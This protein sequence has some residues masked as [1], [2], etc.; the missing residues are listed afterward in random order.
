MLFSF[1]GFAQAQSQPQSQPNAGDAFCQVPNKKNPNGTFVNNQPYLNEGKIYKPGEIGECKCTKGKCVL[2]PKKVTPTGVDGKPIDNV[3]PPDN[4]TPGTAGC[5][6]LS[7][8]PTKPDPLIDDTGGFGQPAT[9]D[10]TKA[11]TQQPGGT[12]P[13]DSEPTDSGKKESTLERVWDWLTASPEPVGAPIDD[14]SGFGIPEGPGSALQPT[15]RDYSQFPL[16]DQEVELRQLQSTFGFVDESGMIAGTEEPGLWQRAWDATKSFATDLGKAMVDGLGSIGDFTTNDEAFPLTDSGE[17]LKEPPTPSV[18]KSDPYLSALSNLKEYP[19][20]SNKE[21]YL[22]Q[23][24]DGTLK[25]YVKDT[26]TGD[27]YRSDIARTYEAAERAALANEQN[28]IA[29]REMLQNGMLSPE[30]VDAPAAAEARAAKIREGMALLRA[31]DPAAISAALKSQERFDTLGRTTDSALAYR[32]RQ[33]SDSVS[34]GVL[35]DLF[36]DRKYF[37][38]V[39]STAWALTGR[40]A[41]D[42]LGATVGSALDMFG[43]THPLLEIEYA[44]DPDAR[45]Q[46]VLRG[47]AETGLNVTAFGAVRGIRPSLS[48][49]LTTVLRAADGGIGF[50]P[51]FVEG[52]SG[53]EARVAAP[54]VSD[55]ATS[56]KGE[57]NPFAAEAR[58]YQNLYGNLA[59]TDFVTTGQGDGMMSALRA[60]MQARGISIPGAADNLATAPEGFAAQASR[61]TSPVSEAPT[62]TSPSTVAPAQSIITPRAASLAESQAIRAFEAAGNEASVVARLQENGLNTNANR[63]IVR[64][65]TGEL[66]SVRDTRGAYVDANTPQGQAILA[67]RLRPLEPAP[68]NGLANSGANTGGQVTTGF[69][70]PQTIPNI[71]NAVLGGFWNSFTG[72]PS[73]VAQSFVGSVIPRFGY[74]G[75]ANSGAIVRMTVPDVA[76]T[77]RPPVSFFSGSPASIS[78]VTRFDNASGLGPASAESAVGV[79]SPSAAAVRL[80][81]ISQQAV[82]AARNNGWTIAEKSTTFTNFLNDRFGTPKPLFYY[83]KAGKEIAPVENAALVP[84]G[85]ISVRQSF[86]T[87]NI[88]KVIAVI[89]ELSAIGQADGL[90]TALFG[91]GLGAQG[92]QLVSD[93][94]Q[95]PLLGRTTPFLTVEGSTVVLNVP[96]RT[97]SPFS[98]TFDRVLDAGAIATPARLTPPVTE[99]SPGRVVTANPIENVT[100]LTDGAPVTTARPGVQPFIENGIPNPSIVETPA[101]SPTQISPSRAP[102]GFQVPQAVKN[103]ASGVWE[104]VKS[105]LSAINPIQPARGQPTQVAAAPPSAEA[106]ASVSGPMIS[107]PPTGPTVR[108]LTTFYA[109]GAGGRVEG[110]WATSRPN[111]EGLKNT[112]GD[113]I[114][115]TLDDVRLGRSTYVTLASDPSRYGQFFNLGDVTYRSPLDGKTYTIKNVIGYVHDTGSAFRGRP[116]KFDVAVGDFRG[117]SASRGQAF[118]NSQPYGANRYHAWQQ[119]NPERARTYLASGRGASPQVVAAG[120]TLPQKIVTQPPSLPSVAASEIA[121]ELAA[122]AREAAKAKAGEVAATIKNRSIFASAKD[123][124]AKPLVVSKDRIVPSANE[125]RVIARNV[126]QAMGGPEA[127]RRIYTYDA[128]GTLRDLESGKIIQGFVMKPV[129]SALEKSRLSAGYNKVSGQLVAINEVTR[130]VL[131]QEALPFN[132]GARPT[133]IGSNRHHSFVP[134]PDGKRILISYAVDY[135]G[136]NSIIKAA[137]T[138]AAN[139]AQW[140]LNTELAAAGSQTS[141]PLSAGAR[142]PKARSIVHIDVFPQKIARTWGSAPI[143]KFLGSV[144][145]IFAGP[146]RVTPTYITQAQFEQALKRAHMGVLPESGASR[147]AEMPGRTT[148]D[149]DRTALNIFKARDGDTKRALFN[150]ALKMADQKFDDTILYKTLVEIVGKTEPAM[151]IPLTAAEITQLNRVLPPELALAT[152]PPASTVVAEVKSPTVESQKE[153]SPRT[154]AETKPPSEAKSDEALKPIRASSAEAPKASQEPSLLQQID[155][156]VTGWFGYSSLAWRNLMSKMSQQTQTPQATVNTVPL[157]PEIEPSPPQARGPITTPGDLPLTDENSIGTLRGINPTPPHAPSPAA[158]PEAASEPTFAKRMLGLLK[159]EA[160]LTDFERYAAAL[161]RALKPLAPPDFPSAAPSAA[162]SAVPDAETSR[163]ISAITP[164]QPPKTPLERHEEVAM[165][166]FAAAQRMQSAGLGMSSAAQRWDW[167]AMARANNARAAAT[168]DFSTAV[169]AYKNSALTTTSDKNKITGMLTIVQT[170]NQ[171][172]LNNQPSGV[173]DALGKQAQLTS[174]AAA[175]RNA[176][177]AIVNTTDRSLM[178]AIRNAMKNQTITLNEAADPLTRVSA[179]L[180]ALQE[181]GYV[182]QAS[183]HLQN[184]A[185]IRLAADHASKL[186]QANLNDTTNAIASTP[187]LPPERQAAIRQALDLVIVSSK[188]VDSILEEYSRLTPQKKLAGKSDLATALNEEGGRLAKGL[189]TLATT[190]AAAQPSSAPRRVAGPDVLEHLRAIPLSRVS[191]PARSTLS[192]VIE[193]TSA[194]LEAR[195]GFIDASRHPNLETRAANVQ[196]ANT[197]LQAALRDYVASSK[198][199]IAETATD[200]QRQRLL[201]GVALVERNA[202]DVSGELTRFFTRAQA[203]QLF[204][205]NALIGRLAELDAPMSA[206]VAEINRGVANAIRAKNN[207]GGI[208]GGELRY[209]GEIKTPESARA[210]EDGE[211]D[212]TIAGG[213]LG[214]AVIAKY[215]AQYGN[216]AIAFVVKASKAAL[217]GLRSGAVNMWEAARASFARNVHPTT[218]VPTTPSQPILRMTPQGPQFVPG[219]QG[220]PTQGTTPQPAPAKPAAPPAQSTPSAGAPAPAPAPAPTAPR[221]AAL[222]AS[223]RDL[224]G[225]IGGRMTNGIRA[226]RATITGLASGI[227]SRLTNAW[228][229]RGSGARP[230]GPSIVGSPVYESAGSRSIFSR[231][232]QQC[233][234]HPIICGGIGVT[235]VGIPLAFLTT[236]WDDKTPT[237]EQPGRTAQGAP[238]ETPQK[239]SSGASKRDPKPETRPGMLRPEAPGPGP[240]SA[241]PRPSRPDSPQPDRSG[242]PREGGMGIVG[243]MLQNA[244]KAV[245]PIM[246]KLWSALFGEKP[247]KPEPPKTPSVTLTANPTSVVS[248]TTTRLSWTG[249]SVARCTVFGPRDATLTSGGASGAITTPPLTH[250]TEFGVACSG[251]DGRSV[252]SATVVVNVR[253]DTQAPIPVVFPSGLSANGSYSFGSQQSGSSGTNVAGGSQNTSSVGSSGGTNEVPVTPKESGYDSRGTHISEWC[254]PNLPI[255]AFT[256]CLCNLE[257]KGCEPWKSS[258]TPS[259]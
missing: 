215:A 6:N 100:G 63:D 232:W 121:R 199:L 39:G 158:A 183:A 80:E 103:A 251:I 202:A 42:I 159:P 213:I 21:Y 164:P 194:I 177:T 139:R 174:S 38:G 61:P 29:Y 165:Q 206:N 55:A 207:L 18:L 171:L 113:P 226:A 10:P 73:S 11:F 20:L 114:P 216:S 233:K 32:L 105:S 244:L 211:L 75:V 234:N 192:K 160:P 236:D 256:R 249:E 106:P 230:F 150:V 228:Q 41:G 220:A 243:H 86:G 90:G 180:V 133:N 173:L 120:Q 157:P 136:G 67:E 144:L 76:G 128:D 111:L 19:S 203:V 257:P 143:D 69:S 223:I 237:T 218:N 217:N 198:A 255:E 219:S 59:R 49:E 163:K 109:P 248:G 212:G 62:F 225:N 182:L 222:R 132:S 118:V 250:S 23:Q 146:P 8:S 176:A 205:S 147:V 155:A 209:A 140:A 186:I 3:T 254:D 167:S 50:R 4:C 170:H 81:E 240:D 71:I 162:P 197:R 37:R 172:L 154:V 153:T 82:D 123:P 178:E 242:A 201:D 97:A 47:I 40:L 65:N 138:A 56:V 112:R 241:P 89:A 126:I 148:S 245:A 168:R 229:S 54:Y 35:G 169:E 33:F 125:V 16:T 129:G 221:M 259:R 5:S 124:D 238:S 57:L 191:E 96:S 26:V 119:I 22:T 31:E 107:S 187:G 247:R 95:L 28:A 58:A 181:Q 204:Q 92:V 104:R 25:G 185:G 224:A 64:T 227:S 68:T 94:G 60:E 193:A 252:T 235:T 44:A 79:V 15:T 116:D 190:I 13:F 43:S 137:I 134:G 196:A 27:V 151:K 149:R 127:L 161:P 98:V 141:I 30:S 108:A 188:K 152:K 12:D 117:W 70:N 115:R 17:L 184:F 131:G 48:T 179:I 99:V 66:V 142:Y 208:I 253:G 231:M 2:I 51:S 246:P 1:A 83:D 189:E 200:A 93:A 52:L 175:L 46:A 45:T 258:P 122:K 85:Y 145:S 74:S 36:G 195:E 77:P 101:Q 78:P 87:S 102:A 88:F 7:P 9:G 34:S 135:S 214:G 14:T 24:P 239:D 166:V 84:D 91:R 53:L 72:L 130:R 110:P 210:P 156:Q